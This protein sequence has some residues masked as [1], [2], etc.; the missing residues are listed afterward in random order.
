MASGTFS[1]DSR[2]RLDLSSSVA[3][4]TINASISVTK[5]AGG[6]YWTANGQWWRIRI[7]GVDQDGSW[8]Y[9]FTAS[10]PQTIGIATRGRNVGYG[11]FLV[12]AWVNMDSGRGQAYAAEWVTINNPATVPGAPY[13]LH[14]SNHLTTNSFGVSY[15]RP[16][17]GG[18]PLLQ[19][20]AEWWRVSDNVL[21]WSDGGPA[22]YTSPNGGATPGAP[23]LLPAT[24]YRVRV[25]SRNAVGWG[26]W[27]G[28]LTVTTLG[29]IY[30]GGV[31]G[32]V[33]VSDGTSWKTA[34]AWT[35]N[36]S[37]WKAAG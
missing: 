18:S 33:Y 30:V 6:G 22:G 9:D 29:G 16:G 12:E 25:R 3:G 8:T 24:A 1:G 11:S 23:A 4:T 28:W 21:V 5:T 36:G 2:Y 17:D 14:Q 20:V 26:P 15:N 10:T 13:N 27:S 19:D 31:L 37:A 32:P 35:S 34:E 7:S